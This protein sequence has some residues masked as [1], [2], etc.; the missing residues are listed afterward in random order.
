MPQSKT[1]KRLG[2]HLLAADFEL[3]GRLMAGAG[4]LIVDIV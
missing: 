2:R 4:V 1:W 3:D